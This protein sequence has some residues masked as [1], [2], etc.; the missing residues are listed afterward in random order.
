MLRIQ[1]SK[2]ASWLHKTD[3]ENPA[4]QEIYKAQEG[5]FHS[6]TEI[7]TSNFSEPTQKEIASVQKVLDANVLKRQQ[8]LKKSKRR[9][10]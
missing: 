1:L 2:I 7:D 10:K 9:R 5:S 6:L 8:E 4:I 3:K